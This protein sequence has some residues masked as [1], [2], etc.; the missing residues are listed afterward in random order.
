MTLPDADGG[1]RWPSHPVAV[2]TAIL[3]LFSLA[4]S[5]QLVK[6]RRYASFVPERQVLYVPSPGVLDRLALSFD[7]VLADFYWIRVL[8]HYGGTRRATEGPKEYELL[9]PLLDITTTLDP[10]FNI[11]YRFGAIFLTE[12]YPDGPGRPDLAVALLQKGVQERPEKWEYLMD[13]GFVYYWWLHDY[14]EAARWFERASDVP[15]SSWWLRS[16]AANTFTLGGNREAS[17]VL[18]TQIHET[19][20]DE[21]R[22]NESLRRL[23]QLDALDEI[24]ALMF[25]T[26]RFEADTGRWPDSWRDLVQ[27]GR[28]DRQP[29]DPFD[30]PYVLDPGTRSVGVSPQSPLW[31]LPDEPPGVGPG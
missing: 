13:I 11:A 8:Q 20:D 24:D 23:R 16:L 12:P 2:A 31:P 6:G 9:Y 14:A 3:L 29:A 17:R 30:H 27:T 10:R 7:A 18:W 26:E 15:G 28:L 22:R 19:A 5:L 1:G 4:V 21:W 25:E